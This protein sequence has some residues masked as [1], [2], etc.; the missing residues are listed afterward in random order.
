M[1]NN[2]SIIHVSS[3]KQSNL[4]P[5]PCT[6]A[7]CTEGGWICLSKCDAA[8]F[9]CPFLLQQCNLTINWLLVFPEP[10]LVLWISKP[11]H[12]ISG[13]YVLLFSVLSWYLLLCFFPLHLTLF[14]TLLWVS[15]CL[16][17]FLCLVEPWVTMTTGKLFGYGSGWLS[18][19]MFTTPHIHLGW[20]VAVEEVKRRAK[21]RRFNW[22]L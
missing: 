11:W 2:L 19:V 3:S 17:G 12:H 22:Y 20:R 15:C 9:W 21:R 14:P 6:Q 13:S 8:A 4:S 16:R 10:D 1:W 18:R 7:C 5:C